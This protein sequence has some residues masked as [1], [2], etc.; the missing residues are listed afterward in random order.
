M[1]EQHQLIKEIIGTKSSTIA[2]RIVDIQYGRN[3]EFWNKYGEKGRKL[4]IR[5]AEYHLPFLTES[6][7][8]N[9]PQLF[10]DYVAWVKILFEGLNLPGEVMSQTLSYTQQ[11]L[12]EYLSPGLSSVTARFI[13]E[14]LDQLEQPVEKPE[15]YI[16]L[17]THLGKV[18]GEYT[19]ALL[20]GDRNRASTLV[21]DLVKQEVPVK[22]IYTKIFQASQYEIG[23]L[24]LSNKISV[25][26]EHYSSAATQMIMSQLYP[27]IFSSERK[28]KTFIGTCIGG[29]LHE[30]GIRMV[31]DFFEM[32]GWDTFYLGANTPVSSVIQTIAGKKADLVGLSASMP[33]HLSIM[34][35]YINEI[36]MGDYEKIP[37]IIIGGNA[38]AKK[39]HLWQEFNADGYARDAF[40]AIELANQITK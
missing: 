22:D 18:A 15:T 7:V 29:E 1:S 34:K 40:S 35:E 23:R 12:E 8:L 14:G 5:D 10:R 31:S 32:E 24:W 20:K 11:A 39:E 13:E 4:S 16:D 21:Q 30:I 36:R 9:D 38:F 27:I 19:E 28:G 6:I 2:E 25:A 17:S 33:Y 26:Q 3:P 37:R